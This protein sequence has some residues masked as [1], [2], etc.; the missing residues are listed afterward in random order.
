MQIFVNGERREV[1]DSTSMGAL[2][3]ELG[4]GGR[5]IAVEVNDELVPRSR[6]DTHQLAADDRI[7]IIHAVGGG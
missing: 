3:A 5:R 4:L 2:V 7:E 1:A 6:F